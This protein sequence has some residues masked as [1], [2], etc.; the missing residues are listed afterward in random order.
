MVNMMLMK[1]KLRG[2]GYFMTKVRRIALV[3]LA[4]IL[5]F[6]PSSSAYAAL[7]DEATL[8]IYNANGIY[9]YNGSAGDDCDPGS[10]GLVDGEGNAAY[11]WNWFAQAGIA[12]VS[13]NPAVIAGIIAN[14][15]AESGINPFIHNDG[16]SYYGMYQALITTKDGA[17]MVATINAA[18]LGQ[19]WGSSSAPPDAMQ[20]ALNIEL[21][22]M[23]RTASRFSATAPNSEPYAFMKNLDKVSQKTPE[24]YAELFLVA[25]EGAIRTAGTASFST[26]LQDEGVRQFALD[27]FGDDYWQA[28]DKRAK[29]A[30]E[31]YD[32]FANSTTSFVA[33][34]GVDAEGWVGGIEGLQKQPA[35]LWRVDDVPMKTF[36]TADGKPSM[37]ILHYTAG[38]TNGIDAYPIGS[39]YPAHFTIDLRDR[40]GY[41]HFSLNEPSLAVGAG[42]NKENWDRYAIQIEIVGCGNRSPGS[43]VDERCM[44]ADGAYTLDQLQPEDWDYLAYYLNA[45][46]KYTGIPL[47][48]TVDWTGNHELSAAEMTTYKGVM[49]HMNVEGN[50]KVD[51]GNIWPDVEAALKRNPSS[52]YNDACIPSGAVSGGL[53][54]E[55]A[56]KFM[57]VYRKIQDEYAGYKTGYVSEWDLWATN[58]AGGGLANCVAVS[59]YF[60]NRY[61]SSYRENHFLNT[62]SGGRTVEC[63]LVDSAGTNSFTDGG[64]TPKVYAI[65]SGPPSSTRTGAR[66]HTGVVLG[67]DE[68]NNKIIIGEAGCSDTDPS[69]R[70][71]TGAFEYP[72]DEFSTEYYV[73]AYTDVL[74]DEIQKTIST[75]V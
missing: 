15:S 72:L 39:A 12:G 46:S 74:Y 66:T 3:F 33:T 73:Y 44:K 45:I 2:G 56:K 22:F 67:I 70:D 54:L 21:D 41:Q 37:I 32:Q 60:V 64:H 47:T 38:M 8:D 24:S 53:T 58:C 26:R 30:R 13:D 10:V 52:T 69:S 29:Y 31:F 17:D 5:V 11:V 65:F 48:S 51:P 23:T 16:S 1:T 50:G 61:T 4:A 63:F 25:F 19:Y 14:F 6:V 20:Q 40:K 28:A 68:P 49:G 9:Y 71:W 34:S 7:P 27:Y 36:L 43:G 35:E 18:G 42:S 57:Q 75:G 62:C 59:Q 55:Q